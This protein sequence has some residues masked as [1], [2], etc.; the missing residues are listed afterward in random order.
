M[1]GLPA[2]G[3]CRD[4]ARNASNP[5]PAGSMWHLVAELH[6]VDATRRHR[7]E[8]RI[9]VEAAG[10]VRSGRPCTV[11]VVSGVEV[12]DACPV[13]LGPSM[14]AVHVSPG[15]HVLLVA[16]HGLRARLEIRRGRAAL[17]A[18]HRTPMIR[19]GLAADDGAS[20]RQLLHLA[21]RSLVLA[22]HRCDGF[23]PL[24]GGIDLR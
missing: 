1:T 21:A 7:I 12:S 23:G 6:R 9:D 17:L 16:D 13:P 18:V 14:T 10:L 19:V 4:G 20:V 22:Q 8:R 24:L 3:R 11:A 5:A 2:Q 15:L